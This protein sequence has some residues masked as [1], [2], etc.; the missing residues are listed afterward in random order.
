METGQTLRPLMAF[1]VFAILL[2]ASGASLI[3]R[4]QGAA[5]AATDRPRVPPTAIYEIVD[6]E[7]LHLGP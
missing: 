4:S 6:W 2:A 1:V 7:S 3:L 5:G